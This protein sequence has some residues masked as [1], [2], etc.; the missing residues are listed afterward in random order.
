[1]IG[2]PG[3]E[4]AKPRHTKGRWDQLSKI[5]LKLAV[6]RSLRRLSWV[7]KGGRIELKRVVVAVCAFNTEGGRVAARRAQGRLGWNRGKRIGE[8]RS[9]FKAQ[10][11]RA[12]MKY[13]VAIREGGHYFAHQ[14]APLASLAHSAVKPLVDEEDLHARHNVRAQL[15]GS[16]S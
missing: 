8:T 15:H 4:K 10:P 16:R 11:A 6:G 14:P 3:P 1:M 13:E 9:T 5:L 2:G 7:E 12:D